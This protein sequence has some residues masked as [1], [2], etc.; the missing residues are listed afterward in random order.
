M[1]I[2]A[3]R[4]A[5]FRQLQ[6]FEAAA[7][8]LSFVGAAERLHLTQPAV[9]MQM[10]HLED[11]AGVALFERQGKK[12]FLT[13]AGEELLSHVRRVIQAMREAGEAMDAIRGLQLGRLTIA[14]VSTAKYF[15]PRL[16]TLFRRAYQ[17]IELRLSVAN[18]EEV[19]RQLRDNVIDLAIMGR[20]PGDLD[21][22]AEPFAPHPHVIIA[23]RDHPLCV[24]RG[25]T[26]KDLSGEVFV[27]REAGSGTRAA[28]ERFFAQHKLAPEIA[29]VMDSNESIKQAVMAGMG[30]SFISSHTIGLEIKA[31]HLVVL[32]IAG[33]PV[34]RRWY[35]VHLTSKR[36]TPVAA[37]F[38]QFV[39]AEAPKYLAAT[40]P[41]S[42]GAAPGRRP[43]ST[44]RKRA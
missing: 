29:M 23:P 9:S 16:L 6:I 40:F 7:T 15:A 22:V 19:L 35:V 32:D 26:I 20:P 28:M 25:L 41:V 2:H 5:T 12:L 10:A 21:T 37:A 33:L 14:A 44:R 17:K 4:H 8:E 13:P 30:I 34:M 43:A 38:K 3:L 39:F 18:R 24:R 1:L 31:K 42:P 36:L 11:N 27:G